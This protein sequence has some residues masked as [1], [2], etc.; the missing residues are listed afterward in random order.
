MKN[1]YYIELF[2]LQDII[3]YGYAVETDINEFDWNIKRMKIRNKIHIDK[4]TAVIEK[5]EFKEFKKD[6][7]SSFF[8]I[9]N[10]KIKSNLKEAGRVLEI[11][12]EGRCTS[13]II[14][15][16]VYKTI[17]WNLNKKTLLEKVSGILGSN[18][19]NENMETIDSKLEEEIGFDFR[20]N[21]DKLGNF[22]IYDLA[23]DKEAMTTNDLS[24]VSKY[25]QETMQNDAEVQKNEVYE[26]E[27]ESKEIQDSLDFKN[28]ESDKDNSAESNISTIDDSN[29][30]SEINDKKFKAQNQAEDIQEIINL[31]EDIKS[32]TG[33]E[34]EI[35]EGNFNERDF[36]EKINENKLEICKFFV[37]ECENQNLK[38]FKA[39]SLLMYISNDFKHE[40]I[41]NF[42]RYNLTAEK[43]YHYI[44]IMLGNDNVSE[45]NAVYL[46]LKDKL[47]R[48]CTNNSI[49][50]QEF[51]DVKRVLFTPVSWHEVNNKFVICLLQLLCIY[52]PEGLLK[53]IIDVKAPIV[54][55]EFLHYL[56][57][58][59]NEEIFRKLLE[60]KATSFKELGF[61]YAYR[62][63]EN[64]CDK[65]EKVGFINKLLSIMKSADKCEFMACILTVL[66]DEDDS[67]M[68]EDIKDY[69][70]EQLIKNIDASSNMKRLLLLLTCNDT[71]KT[72]YNLYQICSEIRIDKFKIEICRTIERLIKNKYSDESIS[73]NDINEV[74]TIL[75]IGADSRLLL[76]SSLNM[77]DIK[78]E[79]AAGN[80]R[81]LINPYLR[82]INYCKWKKALD[83]FII[84]HIYK[85]Q[86]INKYEGANK[87][88]L[89]NNVMDDLYIGIIGMRQI[90]NE[91]SLCGA[92]VIASIIN[93]W[94][95]EG[96]ID[97]D[98]KNKIYDICPE[99]FIKS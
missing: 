67:D 96:Y 74:E 42:E 78:E 65:E 40:I 63:I 17:L 15:E 32:L 29:T 93:Q 44:R 33:R 1:K 2:T 45:K 6:L 92:R 81:V 84:N 85:L 5:S 70:M 28:K 30:C 19:I 59:W 75:G 66:S 23:Q 41:D 87:L 50:A 77:R 94:T 24:N 13:D 47:E 3:L 38:A 54:Y 9:K 7:K 10:N 71:D 82:Q 8:D 16:S 49:T 58:S 35:F 80:Y 61:L 11:N 37:K 97:E 99:W 60:C 56:N 31:Y 48:A 64:K 83:K 20:N 53:L 89:L 62:N 72:I 36:I 52:S 68:V 46:S 51:Q 55:A 88:E 18:D 98:K 14:K 12:E 43:I 21:I 27:R 57:E 22:E 69:V 4:Y 95:H 34:L 73:F 26:A 76:K 86:F 25:I 90:K 39:V 79:L 91:D